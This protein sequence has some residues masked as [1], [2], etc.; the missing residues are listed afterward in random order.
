GAQAAPV[1]FLDWGTYGS[2]YHPSL[3][4]AHLESWL[5]FCCDH[6]A[7]ACTGR[8][9]IVSYVALGIGESLH[10][11]FRARVERW[12]E[13]PAFRQPHFDL[14]ALPALGRV[15]AND[16]VRFL[17]DE[18]NTS[19]PREYLRDIPDRIIQKTG[20]DFEETVQLLENAERGMMWPELYETLPKAPV[21]LTQEEDILLE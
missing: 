5:T 19:C 12:R 1:H 21:N 11:E 6:L 7:Q 3:R 18:D 4:T 9:R 14:L 2:G 15:S 17:E 16:L 13:R 10:E 8:S 20:G